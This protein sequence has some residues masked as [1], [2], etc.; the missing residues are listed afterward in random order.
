MK[1]LLSLAL[2]LLIAPSASAVSD[3][4]PDVMGVY[5]DQDAWEPELYAPPFT[6]FRAYVILTNPTETQINGFEFGY[7]HWARP[8]DRNLITRV[9]TNY[10]PGLII[11][12]PPLDPF[13]GS[14]AIGLPSPFPAA[15]AVVLLSWDY[16]LLAPN[17]VMHLNL[18]EAT[19]SSLGNGFPAY[20]SDTGVV[21][22][23]FA[24]TCFGTG[25]RVNEF[26][27]LPVETHSFGRVKSLYR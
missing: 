21:S 4:S 9:A 2:L 19:P 10:P 25:A 11:I 20:W 22:A 5:F 16:M 6:Q 23:G 1:T 12:D 17:L 27:P 3:P 18:T 15:E 24:Q 8:E 14:Y 7:D 13:V 26:C